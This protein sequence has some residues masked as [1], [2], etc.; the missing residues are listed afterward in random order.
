MS[1][2][3]PPLSDA[4]REALEL[5]RRQGGRLHRN[6]AG[7]GPRQFVAETT[8]FAD[9]FPF[10]TVRSLVSRGAMHWTEHIGTSPT[11]AQLTEGTP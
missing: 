5:A 10:A 11:E 6:S 2:K 8:P 4:Q 7:W 1:R 3:P 9:L